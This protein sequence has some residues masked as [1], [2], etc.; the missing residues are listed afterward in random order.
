MPVA[1]AGEDCG[2]EA[3]AFARAQGLAL[4]RFAGSDLAAALAELESLEQ[5]R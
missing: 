2:A 3:E 1:L 4:V 5:V